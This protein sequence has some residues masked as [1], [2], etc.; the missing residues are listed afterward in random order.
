MSDDKR[1]PWPSLADYDALAAELAEAKRLDDEHTAVVAKLA[2]ENIALRTALLEAA[3][4]MQN[5]ESGFTDYA[6]KLRAIA[7]GTERPA[8]QPTAAPSM[9]QWKCTVCDYENRVE[10]THCEKC[11]YSRYV[12][13][14]GKSYPRA[15]MYGAAVQTP[16]VCPECGRKTGHDA[17]CPMVTES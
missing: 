2:S 3:D 16:V 4:E 13:R 1:T 15:G 8:N 6:K 11:D 5:R 14:D 7:R 10:A 17:K 12:M 9:P